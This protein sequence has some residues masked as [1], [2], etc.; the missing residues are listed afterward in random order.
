MRCL[1]N[2]YGSY[3]RAAYF[4][5]PETESSGRTYVFDSWKTPWE[6][7]VSLSSPRVSF[8]RDIA[9]FWFL[10]VELLAMKA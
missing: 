3:V 6:C 7:Y 8:C 9:G 2:Q 5:L 10:P 1:G 4:L